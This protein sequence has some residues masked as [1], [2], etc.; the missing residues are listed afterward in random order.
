ML[1][2]P[3]TS[4]YTAD[5]DACDPQVGFVILQKQTD[6]IMRPIGYQSYTVTSG[7]QNLA[8]T[9]KHFLAVVGVVV[10]LLP[11]LELSRFLVCTDHEKIRWFLTSAEASRKLARWQRR[12]LE[13]D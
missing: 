5:T 8:T 6:G 7:E 12:L 11:Y 2:L 4:Q 13:L 1:A 10:L 3:R 9:H